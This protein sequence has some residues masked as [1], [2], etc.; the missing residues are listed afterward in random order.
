MAPRYPHRLRLKRIERKPKRWLYINKTPDIWI[1]LD[2][3]EIEALTNLPG[4]IIAGDALPDRYYRPSLERRGDP[5]LVKRG[6]MHLHLSD[7][8]LA[9]VVQYEDAVLLVRVDDHK[10]FHLK[11]EGGDISEYEVAQAEQRQRLNI[12]PPAADQD[13]E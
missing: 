3:A 8:A 12:C 10:T 13:Q 2:S 1:R 7:K 4:F 11:P 6:I 9:F 5:L